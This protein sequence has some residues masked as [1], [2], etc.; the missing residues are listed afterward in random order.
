MS[1]YLAKGKGW[2]YDFT[3]KGTRYTES[4]FKT[5]A[6][7]KQA[8]FKK[9]EEV[10]NPRQEPEATKAPT[11]MGF[12]EL[13]NSRLD[14]LKEYKTQ[15]Y[16]NDNLYLFRRLVSRWKNLSCSEITNSM[17]QKYILERARVSHESA[18]YDLRLLRA[19]FNYGKKS[20]FGCFNP[21]EGVDF[22]PTER[23]VKYVPSQGDILKVILV[24]DSDTRDYLYTIKE[25]FGRMS[26][27]NRL[28]WSDVNLK[29]QYVV[30]YTR[31]KKG[32]ILTPRKIPMT[33]KLY[34]TLS[35]RFA[36]RDPSKPWV[37]WHRYWSSKAGKFAEGPYRDRKKLMK[38]LCEK[39]GVKYFRYHA[40]RHAGASIM[41]NANVP[42]GSIQKILGH[43]NRRTTEIYL[44]AVGEAEKEAM[45]IYERVSAKSHTD[46]HTAAGSDT[47]KVE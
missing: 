31:K 4:W 21:T 26:E 8:E 11:D 35:A 17:V 38:I 2:R 30:L 24:A 45:A 18:N 3:L 42:I 23:K 44:H 29:E 10:L 9:R 27:I 13:V 20:K 40:L 37:F 19:L 14:V 16:Y 43:E 32:S 12:L 1:V 22:L 39:A 28:T 6:Q 47:G 34:E 36:N 7:A 46:S 15:S 25:T 5:K 33:E 41:D